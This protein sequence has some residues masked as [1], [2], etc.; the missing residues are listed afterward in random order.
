MKNKISRYGLAGGLIFLILFGFVL[1]AQA[2]ILY[3]KNGRNIE[4]VIQKESEQDVSLDIGSGVVKF[5][6]NEI[7]SIKRS[8]A[9]GDQ[10]IRDRWVQERAAAQARAREIQKKLEG[11]PKQA[12]LDKESGKMTVE[13]TLNKKVKADLVLDTGA[14]LIVLSSKIAKNLGV[15]LSAKPAKAGDILELTLA[16]GRKVEGRKIILD[17]VSV[18][19]SEVQKV[20]AAILPEQDNSALAHDGLLGMSFL[21]N[22][23][24]KIDQ[25]EKKLTLEKL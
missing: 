9:G 10:A 1:A 21:K 17:N 8:L 15:N 24:F 18:Q 7:E 2:D 25:K 23:T 11:A 4:G 13:T 14:S 22:F 16:D 12:V 5:S 6:K 19:G 20:E 3:L